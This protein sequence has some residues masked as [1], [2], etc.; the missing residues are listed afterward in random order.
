MNRCL[1]LDVEFSL[2]LAVRDV[3]I[4]QLELQIGGREEQVGYSWADQ[5]NIM[6]Q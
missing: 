4:V 2:R 1:Q 3:D 5:P 6:I